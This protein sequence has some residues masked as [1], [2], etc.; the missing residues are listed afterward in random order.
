MKAVVQRA[1]GGPE[2]LSYQ[3]LDDPK[4]GPGDVL[5][6]VGA[7]ALNRLDVL[8]RQ[9]P[10][11]LPGFALPHVAGMDVAGTVVEVGDDVEAFTVGD[12]VL[13]NPALECG[14]CEYCRAGDDGFCPSVRVVGGTWPGGYAELCAVPADHLYRIPDGVGFEEAATIPTS[15]S[16]AWH[17]I[18]AVGALHIGETLLVHGAGSGVT[19]AAIQIAK[20]CGARVIVTARSEK[21]LELAARLGA[22]G[23]V[24][25]ATENLAARCRELT[26][27]RGADIAF[28]HVGPELFQQTIL[29]LRT[30]GRVVFAGTTTGAEA[31]FDLAYA[32]HFG[33][34]LIGVDPY[35][36]SEFG[37]MLDFYWQGGFEPV[38]DSRFPLADAA[39]AQARMESG[40]AAGKIL[41]LP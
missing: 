16:T 41:L 11:L 27:G 17:A 39:G 4:V 40:E 9:G 6:R 10:A 7:A 25:T 34:A 13:V 2:V 15:Y 12:R 20:R 1:F 32:Y 23:V 31:R 8:Q 18:V 26:E 5:L 30:R 36:A 21:K 29:S 38:I 24:N 19:I 37:R 35:S 14:A 33:I 22:D 28:D 3:D